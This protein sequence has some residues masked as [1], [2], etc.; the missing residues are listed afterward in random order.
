MGV[1]SKILMHVV[2]VMESLCLGGVWLPVMDIEAVLV[3]N[4]VITIV[5]VSAIQLATDIKHVDVKELPVIFTHLAAAIKGVMGSRLLVLVTVDVIST[6]DVK[7]AMNATVTSL[8]YLVIWHVTGMNV[9]I[10]TI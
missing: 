9:G 7:Y 2:V 6:K 5:S 3:I 1:I 4:L 10:V 8:V